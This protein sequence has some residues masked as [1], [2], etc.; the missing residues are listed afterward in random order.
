MIG[1]KYDFINYNGLRKTTFKE[2]SKNGNPFDDKV[3]VIDEVHNLISRIVNK[4]K[5]S[6]QT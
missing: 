2:I 1:E 6:N 5:Q 4:I 3:I